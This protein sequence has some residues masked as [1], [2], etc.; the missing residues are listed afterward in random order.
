MPVPL[1]R[2]TDVD[3]TGL[4]P[5]RALVAEDDENYAAY[6]AA[7]LRRF[8]FDVSVAADGNAALEAARELPFDVAVIDYSMPGMNGLEL[9]SALR[10]LHTCAD[11]YALMVTAHTELETKVAA[12]RLGY[13]DFITKATGDTE[14]VAKLGAARRLVQRQR[15]LDA[16]VR[17]LYGL[18]TRDELT[19][20]F[21]RRYFYSETER[22]LADGC[23]ITLALFDLDDFKR[24]NDNHGH[25]AGDQIL[26]DVGALFLRSTRADD[27]I[28]RYGGDEFVLVATQ[29]TLDEV[30]GLAARLN[31]EIGRLRWTFGDQTVSVGSTSGVASSALYD[32][33]NLGQ[34]LA[35]CDRDL[36][37]NKRAARGE[38]R[39]EENN[40]TE[41]RA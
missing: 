19:G 41:A 31:V 34:L 23:R 12:L 2:R 9:I 32:A 35:A 29:E 22:M 26:R 6:I 38:Q 18:A 3:S 21:N 25:L 7:L 14:M 17:E 28:A 10:S 4:P 8:G 33:P 27:L 1:R 37:K 36:Y 24:V 16:T 5:L 30:L 15:R 13:D 39:P 40:H 11:L 20:L